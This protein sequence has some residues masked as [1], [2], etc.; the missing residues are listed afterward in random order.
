LQYLAGMFVL[1]FFF[2]EQNQLSSSPVAQDGGSG[3]GPL[4]SYAKTVPLATPGHMLRGII[5]LT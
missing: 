1:G 4:L 3:I 5:N 2:S